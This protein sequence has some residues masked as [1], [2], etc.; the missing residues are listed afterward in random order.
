M[1]DAIDAARAKHMAKQST[2]VAQREA[3][4]ATGERPVVTAATFRRVAEH[5]MAEPGDPRDT[6]PMPKA[7]P[8]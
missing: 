4:A 7:K 3:T 8:G 5:A 6:G 2:I 1:A